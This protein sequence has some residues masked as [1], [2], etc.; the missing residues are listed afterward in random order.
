M[1]D[2]PK[3]LWNRNFFLLWQGQFAS[4]IGTQAY[5]IGESFWIKHNTQSGLLVG[6]SLMFAFLPGLFLFPFGGT[7]ADFASRKKILVSTDAIR[8]IAVLFLA[9]ML[10]LQP[11]N[12]TGVLITIYVVNTVLS[13]CQSFFQPAIQSLLPELVPKEKLQSANSLWYAS[14]DASA[15]IGLGVGGILYRIL[16]APLLFLLDGVSY[17]ASAL[18]ECFIHLPEKPKATEPQKSHRERARAFFEETKIG[19]R[20]VA[21]N[22]GLR[23]L[24]FVIAFY[25]CLANAAFFVWIPFYVEDHL[26]LGVLWYGIILAV[27]G[28]GGLLGS[29]LASYYDPPQPTKG[30]LVLFFFIVESVAFMGFGTSRNVYASM[31]CL[32]VMD[33]MGN[34][35]NVS[36]ITLIQ[37]RTPDALLGRVMGALGLVTKSLIPFA[38]AIAGIITDLLHRQVGGAFTIAGLCMLLLSLWLMIQ[39]RIRAYL[40]DPLTEDTMED[41]VLEI[42][43]EKKPKLLGTFKAWMLGGAALLFG[44]V[45]IATVYGFFQIRHQ[46]LKIGEWANY[47]PA[48][49]TLD[50]QGVATI[51]ADNWLDA[52]E[53]M[54]FTH[55]AERMWQMDLSRRVAEGSLSEL[56]GAGVLQED[57]L[58]RLQDWAGTAERGVALLSEDERAYCEAYTRGVNRFIKE[59]ESRWG[60]EYKLLGIDPEEWTC[61]DC[62]LV[63][64]IMADGLSSGIEADLIRGR[65]REVLDE[66]WDQFLFP[67]EHPWNQ[68]VFRAKLSHELPD[69]AA[70]LPQAPLQL[71]R[72]EPQ[73]VFQS[74]GSNAWMWRGDGGAYLANDPHLDQTVPQL[75]YAMRVRI[76]E[77]DW[78][79]GASLPGVPGILLGMNAHYAWGFTNTGEDFDDLLIETL[80]EDR[81]QYLAA[82]GE[83]GEEIWQPL[84]K[85]EL[86]IPVADAE[87]HVE[88]VLVTHRGTIIEMPHWGPHAYT[89]QW[90]GLKPGLLSLPLVGINR[91]H[92]WDS[93]NQAIDRFMV[94]SQ[95]IY[96]MDRAGNMGYRASGTGIIRRDHGL[97]PRP[98][99]DGEWLGLETVAERERLFFPADADPHFL[100]NANDDMGIDRFGG[101]YEP[102]TRKR[103]LD[104]KLA[105]TSGYQRR[106]MENLQLDTYSHFHRGL[107]LW[108]A[109][110]ADPQDAAAQAM[111]QGWRDWDGTVEGNPA[112]YTQLKT[113][114]KDCYEVL[115][116]RLRSHHGLDD[117][118][119]YRYGAFMKN[120]WLVKLIETP[121]SLAV[122]GTTEKDFANHIIARFQAEQ[123]KGAVKP[124]L[125]ANRWGA[126]HPFAAEVPVFG[127]LFE[128]DPIEQ[129]GG[130]HLLRAEWPTYGPAVRF[131]WDLNHPEQSTW[132]FPIGQSGHIGSPHY[133]DMQQIWADG[134][135]RLPVFNEPAKWGL[136]AR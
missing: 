56:F 14:V 97:Y 84:E 128:V 44:A 73:Q 98:A 96:Y 129:P 100:A 70:W 91:A 83:N 60:V 8:G 25:N 109:Q 66:S 135:Q 39:P 120:A 33:I 90:L 53:A 112:A 123:A 20:Y 131:V 35:I 64:L 37:T 18:S 40:T 105:Q 136:P 82:R 67:V 36:I 94:P 22:T 118:K 117:K 107:G 49:I 86:R 132:V 95:N 104:E 133:K 74:P 10:F 31:A 62:L 79:V 38:M 23:N 68:P 26:G 125:E 52:I 85:R 3:K 108:L 114:A 30:W 11:T 21:H 58:P 69:P 127:F 124:H 50:H 48:R 17:L 46:G 122:F 16:G 24:V 34:Y 76:S 92:D 77:T 81:T 27:G 65:W 41:P 61:S 47:A 89:R 106:D 63:Q 9:A 110:H 78:A 15:L 102:A 57:R 71:S 103:R 5:L 111:I 13:I 29:L 54:G 75:L 72:T 4:L 45:L 119:K 51:E 43:T 101:Y 19:I 6:L 42:P 121:E 93:F 134:A 12:I 80:N 59:Y 126:Q 2:A 7:L 113:I 116:D 87:D 32:L 55:A 99:V 115:V 28:F 130:D 88:E 1:N